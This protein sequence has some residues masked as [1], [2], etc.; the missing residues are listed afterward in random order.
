MKFVK[1]ESQ[2]FYEQLCEITSKV[3]DKWGIP[4]PENPKDPKKAV[5]VAISNL[6][7][8]ALSR[9]FSAT[10]ADDHPW[11]SIGLMPLTR[12]RLKADDHHSLLEKA[13]EEYGVFASVE[14]FGSVIIV[15][16]AADLSMDTA[17]F[18]ADHVRNNLDAFFDLTDAPS[19]LASGLNLEGF[20][21]EEVSVSIHSALWEDVR[22]IGSQSLLPLSESVFFRKPCAWDLLRARMSGM[23]C[24]QFPDFSEKAFVNLRNRSVRFDRR[25]DAA[26]KAILKLARDTTVDLDNL[27]GRNWFAMVIDS[28]NSLGEARFSPGLSVVLHF[29]AFDND[30]LFSGVRNLCIGFSLDPV[31]ALVLSELAQNDPLAFHHLY[32]D[33]EKTFEFVSVSVIPDVYLAAF[34]ATH[35]GRDEAVYNELVRRT[36]VEK[37]FLNV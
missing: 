16:L 24:S 4:F 9:P 11:S 20:E 15:P 18:V 35:E 8:S 17:L 25:S 28:L 29:T 27:E 21:N 14:G 33:Q 12:A 26:T 22:D 5:N 10:Y 19:V 13:G 6:I 2:R 7:S 36:K 3:C 37:E 30:G 1:T 34:N 32:E 23:P 31:Q